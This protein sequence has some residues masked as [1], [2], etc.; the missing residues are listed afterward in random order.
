MD[1]LLMFIKGGLFCMHGFFPA[2]E[3]G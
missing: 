1:I 2:G 3:K